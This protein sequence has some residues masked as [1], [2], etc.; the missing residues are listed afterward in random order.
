M[1]TVLKIKWHPTFLCLRLR[2]ETYE[3]FYNLLVARHGTTRFY[4][5]GKIGKLNLWKI[6]TD[7]F[8]LP[9]TSTACRGR[10]SGNWFYVDI[11]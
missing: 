5:N 10:Q 2:Y 1:T 7:A 6:Y 3:H 9:S 4:R 8:N 11:I